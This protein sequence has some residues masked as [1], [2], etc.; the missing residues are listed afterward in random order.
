MTALA[1]PD[2]RLHGDVLAR[3]AELDLAV[4]VVA[5]GPPPWLRAV[6]E[7]ALREDA[8]AYPDEREALAA[9]AARHGRTPEEV[10]LTNGAAEA[11]WV[12]AAALRP[13]QAVCVHPS[14][15]EPELALR[16][17]GH[18]VE[19]V[20]LDAPHVLDPGRVPPGADLV[21]LGNPTNPTGVLHDAAAVTALA[22]PGRV[23]VVDE[24][25]MDLVPDERHSVAHRRDVPGLVVVRSLTKLLAIPGL[26]AGHLLAPPP[27][28]ARLRAHRPG[29]SVNALA[30][31]ATIA[32][33]RRP[34]HARA[35]AAAT[36]D[37]RADLRR[38]LRDLGLPAP[39]AAANF[40]LTCAA[41]GTA[42]AL[43]GRGIAVRPCGS[44]PGLTDDH[45]RLTVRD[46]EAHARLAAA[47]R[48]LRPCDRP[49]D[50]KVAR[51][52]PGPPADHPIGG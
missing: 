47:L 2:L 32:A 52:R 19:R 9:V 29:W 35:V 20:V 25:F 30:L 49:Q 48:D 24:A 41:P 45:L 23:V 12:L 16:Q 3:G 17:A 8:A 27:L 4:N 46:P 38:R 6:L 39:E 7:R 22:R 44:F 28:A 14:F 42:R 51:R 18:P 5:G 21:V 34:E 13:R 36:A 50:D 40:V 26:R 15:T 11:F 31:A 37:A 10:V 43:R 33:A 1:E